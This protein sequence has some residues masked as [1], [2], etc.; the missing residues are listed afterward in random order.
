LG[1]ADQRIVEGS[2]TVVPRTLCFI[3]DAG[4]VLLLRGASDKALW[5]NLYNG[6]GGHVEPRE[7]VFTA[8]LREVQEETGILVDRLQLRGV[9]NIPSAVEGV[10]VMLFVFTASASSRDA[11]PSREGAVEWVAIDEVHQI[12]LV[13]DLPV[14]LPVVLSMDE[15]DA[16]FFAYYEYDEHHQ[17]L[18]RFSDQD[19][20]SNS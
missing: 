11:Q 13:E 6:V 20:Q 4:C 15:G 8:A 2:Y 14:L 3:I 7:D 9:I 1:E 5:P 10:G 19:R 18:I 12:D 16:P 17:L